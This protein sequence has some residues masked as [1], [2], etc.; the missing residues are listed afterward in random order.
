MAS[1]ATLTPPEEV[2]N[3]AKKGL[4]LASRT[5]LVSS[6]HIRQIGQALANGEP[7]TRERLRHIGS[8]FRAH[9]SDA[10]TPQ[11]ASE[12]HPSPSW[13]AWLMHGG[14]AGRKWAAK[15]IGKVDMSAGYRDFMDEVSA[16]GPV[17]QTAPDSSS[18]VGPDEEY[19]ALLNKCDPRILT[20]SRGAVPPSPFGPR[21]APTPGSEREYE[22]LLDLSDPRIRASRRKK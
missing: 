20:A 4:E 13:I 3:S 10:S 2:Q 5:G 8:F 15:N 11:W 7:Q 17:P 19:R 9:S 14:E 6:S 22:A 16:S 18:Q 12:E 1:L 21:E